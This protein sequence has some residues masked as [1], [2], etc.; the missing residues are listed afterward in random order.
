VTNRPYILNPLVCPATVRKELGLVGDDAGWEALK[1]SNVLP[2]ARRTRKGARYR[3]AEVL[4][5]KAGR[6]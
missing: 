1:A 5:L 4:A 6:L 2:V 3:L